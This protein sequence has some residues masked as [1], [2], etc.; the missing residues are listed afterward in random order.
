MNEV[1]V[2][3]THNSYHLAPDAEMMKMVTLFSKEAEAWKYSHKKLDEQLEMG[4]RQFELDVFSDPKGGLYAVAGHP[5]L[6]AMKKPGIKVLHVPK[7]DFQSNYA[8]FVEALKAVKDWS[9]KNQNHVPV[10][11]LVELKDRAEVPLGPAPV[12]FDRK[13]LEDLEK[14][15][16]SVFKRDEL[17]TPDFVRGEEATLREAVTGK[18]WPKLKE[19]RGRVMFCLDNEGAH[20][21][22]YLKGNPSLENRLIFVSVDRSHPAA[23]FMKRNNP[24]GGFGEIQKLVKEG[25]MVRT[26]ADANSKEARANDLNRAKKAMESG[27]QFVSTDF[28]EADPKVGAYVVRLPDGVIARSNPVSAANGPAGELE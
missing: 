27:A 24:V 4:V 21:E 9:A 16:L 17:V 28:P 19:V 14:E 1:Q 26:R 2:M 11:I 10:M 20:R 8:T 22:I 12:K 3:G 25:F 13:E 15:I 18:G 7:F 6:A 23:A 5:N